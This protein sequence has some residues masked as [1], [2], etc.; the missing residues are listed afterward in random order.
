MST[1]YYARYNTC[2]C[3]ERYDEIHIGKSSVGW[4][5]SFRGYNNECDNFV[6][7][8]Y[9]ELINVIKNN[10]MNIY[11]EYGHKTSLQEFK[12]LVE[13]KRKSDNDS[14]RN[15]LDKISQENSEGTLARIVFRDMWLDDKGNNFCRREFS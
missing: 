12:D 8:S 14:Y 15:S 6:I 11:D 4:T 7:K 3:C 9:K 13:S 2:E 1:N 10:N 5:F